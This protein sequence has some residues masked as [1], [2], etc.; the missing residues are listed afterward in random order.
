MILLNIYIIYIIY[1]LAIFHLLLGYISVTH[2][3]VNSLP[4]YSTLWFSLRLFHPLRYFQAQSIVSNLYKTH[5]SKRHINKNQQ[6]KHV[7]ISF[8]NYKIIQNNEIMHSKK[9]KTNSSARRG[10]RLKGSVGEVKRW[11]RMVERS[12]TMPYN[13]TLLAKNIQATF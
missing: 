13:I 8:Y 11:R 4:I 5:N 2:C 1:L 6:W 10:A 9:K 7:R 3:T 12:T